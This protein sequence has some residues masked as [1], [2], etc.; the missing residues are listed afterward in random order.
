L[1]ALVLLAGI[2]ELLLPT[3]RMKG[4][5][6]SLLG[7]LVLLGVLQPLV[8][9]IRGQISL[10]LPS[11]GTVVADSAPANQ[12]AVSAAGQAFDHLVAG[13]VVRM[14]E[15]VPGV[16][17]ASATVTFGA[18]L[19]TPQGAQIRIATAGGTAGGTAAA[20]VRRVVAAG[21]GLPTQDVTV[22]DW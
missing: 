4:Y 20:R 6:R 13:Q 10:Q 11:L 3:G 18:D 16:A 7:L 21:L 17:S 14:A 15:Q 2:A 8:G 22:E 1:A 12:A 5:A 19:R 9:V